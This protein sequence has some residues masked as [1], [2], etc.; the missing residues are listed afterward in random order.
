V[1]VEGSL[2]P[3][4]H[5]LEAAALVSSSWE[6]SQGRRRRLYALT[7]DGKRALEEEIEAWRVF[8]TCVEAVL[9]DTP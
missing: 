8:R 3:A 6:A 5:R 2:Y 9:E 4:L 7:R 1:V